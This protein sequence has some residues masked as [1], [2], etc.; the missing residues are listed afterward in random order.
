ME[1]PTHGAVKQRLQWIKTLL[2]KF[3]FTSGTLTAVSMSV[4]V[5]I[6]S[7]WFNISLDVF[8]LGTSV[9]VN[10]HVHKLLTYSF[11]H[12]DATQ[13]LLSAGVL[14][15]FCSSL[16][17]GVGTVRFT[18]LLLLLSAWTGLM[19]ALLEL[20][21]F[22]AAERSH[23]QG[24]IPVSLALL[25]MATVHSPMRKAVLLGV[26]V[27]TAVLPWILLLFTLIIPDT[28]FFC[29]AIAIIVGEIYG[30][31]WFSLLDM[32]EARASVLDKKMPFRLLRMLVGALYIPAS[33]EER[34]KILHQPC[35]P[36]PGSYPV[37]AYAP[38]SSVPSAQAAGALPQMYEGWQ[39]STYTQGSF[40]SPLFNHGHSHEHGFG[41]SHG[42]ETP[43]QTGGY[44]TQGA[45]CGQPYPS[46]LSTYPVQADG[47]RL[48]PTLP[49][50]LP[51]SLPD[52]LQM[53]GIVTS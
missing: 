21:L 1:L 36:V 48:A 17:K 53:P 12:K 8:S 50:G 28:V 47:N 35:A 30:M 27:P 51:A 4:I 19:H 10:G 9:V 42:Q 33:I 41:H 38:A 34:R 49:S 37:Q 43:H 18:Y 13:L 20:L 7:K 23:V 40:T 44:W 5:F 45:P 22:S 16:E 14:V 39:H 6:V 26:S 2:P 29:N 46:P 52:P 32:S 24:F 31:G 25:G 3:E 15:P 11:F